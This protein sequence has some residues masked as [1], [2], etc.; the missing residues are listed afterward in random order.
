MTV[1]VLLVLVGACYAF[2]VARA[3][4][5]ARRIPLAA[6]LSFYGGLVVIGGALVGPMDD[7]ADASFTWHMVEHL[8][9]MGLGAPLL[10][11]GAPL[12]VALASLPPRPASTLARVL[13][14]APIGWLTNPMVALVLFLAVMYGTHFSPFYE[15]S[16]E[17]A[18]VHAAEHAL[19]LSAAFLFWTAIL[20]VAPAPHAATHPL[21]ILTLILAM[22]T[23][24][25]LGFAFYVARH[26]L[27]AHYAAMPGALADQRDA[28]TVMWLGGGLPLFVALLWC[29]ADW[30]A[31]ERRLAT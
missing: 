18:A 4:A 7:L 14:S 28:G 19:Y 24:G 5:R 3:R 22:P 1:I 21:R 6:Q 20:A 25:F 9:L 16:L 15:A 13:R 17:N 11:L 31:R 10:V 27:Y 30:G 8:L 2:G 29:G 23:T 12:R 26:P